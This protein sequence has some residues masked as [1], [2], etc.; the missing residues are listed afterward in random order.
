M[1]YE[2]SA[3]KGRPFLELDDLPQ[4]RNGVLARLCAAQRLAQAKLSARR[5]RHQLRNFAIA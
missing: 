5:A 2:A 3:K 4:E 1:D